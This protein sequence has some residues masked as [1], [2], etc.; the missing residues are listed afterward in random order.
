MKWYYAQQMKKFD[1]SF[2][3]L[4]RVLWVVTR[5]K[6]CN[7]TRHTSTMDRNCLRKEL[8][9]QLEKF[10]GMTVL[11]MSRANEQKANTEQVI[12]T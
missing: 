12:I 11:I 2:K 10:E 8:E 1:R 3:P 5:T 9:I 6:T 4:E 7:I